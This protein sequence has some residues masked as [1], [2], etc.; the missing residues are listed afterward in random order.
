[1]KSNHKPPGAFY[2]IQVQ[3]ELDRS[4]EVYFEGL[5]VSHTFNGYQPPITTLSS[6]VIDQSALRGLLC[7]LWDLNLTLISLQ[8]IEEHNKKDEENEQE[9][10]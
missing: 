1:M 7:K 3:G 4:W 2:K 9:I 8:R 6:L 5:A 10:K